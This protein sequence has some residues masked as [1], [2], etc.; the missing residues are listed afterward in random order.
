MIIHFIDAEKVKASSW[1]AYGILI[2][3]LAAIVNAIK[4]SFHAYFNYL[5]IAHVLIMIN[6]SVMF[7]GIKRKAI[8][9]PLT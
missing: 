7:V 1:I 2:L 9:E 6:L 8:S 5:D 3:F 4:F